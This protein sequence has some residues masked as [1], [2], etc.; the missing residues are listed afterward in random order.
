MSG[1]PKTYD[2]VAMGELLI[3]FTASGISPPGNELYECNPG[4]APANLLVGLSR[5][6]GHGCFIGKV[7]N[8]RFGMHLASVLEQNGISTEGLVYSD[9]ANTTLAFVHLSGEGKEASA[10]SGSLEPTR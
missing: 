1:I 9:Q 7:G 3:D 6:G 4:G 8:D 10:F 2:A 5:L